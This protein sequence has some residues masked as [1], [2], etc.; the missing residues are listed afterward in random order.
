[1]PESHWR[2]V[3]DYDV[4][5]YVDAVGDTWEFFSADGWPSGLGC[6]ECPGRSGLYCIRWIPTWS[7]RRG[8]WE[9]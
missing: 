5:L 8:V 1:M 4:V 2:C 9:G 7:T 6:S 3:A